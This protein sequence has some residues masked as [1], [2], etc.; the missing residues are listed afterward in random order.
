MA[1]AWP[2]RAPARLMDTREEW[3]AFSAM[4]NALSAKVSMK[5]RKRGLS[6]TAA[7]ASSQ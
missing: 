5:I 6:L 2:V 4:R 3:G 1:A 7:A